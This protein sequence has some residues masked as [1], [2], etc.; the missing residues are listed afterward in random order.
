MTRER[1]EPEEGDEATTEVEDSLRQGLL[2]VARCHNDLH[3]GK[4]GEGEGEVGGRG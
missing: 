2:V 1:A 4:D 3:Q